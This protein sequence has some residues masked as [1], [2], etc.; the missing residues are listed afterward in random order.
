MSEW[1]D[2]NFPLGDMVKF[3]FLP[4]SQKELDRKASDDDW[5]DS[6]G[7][8]L[9]VIHKR[10]YDDTTED[11]DAFILAFADEIGPRPKYEEDA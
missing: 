10:W 4:P 9:R 5:Y 2:I 6:V 7:L 3:D 8:A 11:E 1:G